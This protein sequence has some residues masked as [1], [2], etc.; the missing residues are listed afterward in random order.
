MSVGHKTAATRNSLD[1]RNTPMLKFLFRYALGAL[2]LSVVTMVAFYVWV[3]TSTEDEREAGIARFAEIVVTPLR[4]MTETM[5]P[6]PE[7][8]SL[9]RKRWS[10]SGKRTRSR[11]RRGDA[12]SRRGPRRS[13]RSTTS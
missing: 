7:A 2:A 1:G 8:S 10:G 9:R 3:G 13:R 6:G 4:V 12:R 5:F 11:R